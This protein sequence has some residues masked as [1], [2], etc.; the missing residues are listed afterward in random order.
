[1]DQFRS[2]LPSDHSLPWSSE[3]GFAPLQRPV[4]SKNY[5]TCLVRESTMTP[6]LQA[7]GTTNKPIPTQEHRCPYTVSLFIIQ[8]FSSSNFYWVLNRIIS[9]HATGAALA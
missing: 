4:K 6:D 8:D 7:Q 2:N 9:G 1:M 3:G 5:S